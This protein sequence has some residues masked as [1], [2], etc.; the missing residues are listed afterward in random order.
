MTERLPC[1]ACNSR[2]YFYYR[3]RVDGNGNWQYECSQCSSGSQ[4]QLSPDVYFDEKKGRYQTDPNLCDRKGNEIPFSSRR[5]K[6]AIMRRLN[7]REAGDKVRG[8][9]N[10]DKHAAK[11]WEGYI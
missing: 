7:V 9:R 11:Q 4:P 10:F 5:E 1:E 3:Q 2:D 6:A 8:M